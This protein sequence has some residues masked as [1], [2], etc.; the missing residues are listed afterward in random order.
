MVI[1][2]PPKSARLAASARV[3]RGFVAALL[4]AGS[5]AHAGDLSG[6]ARIIGGDTIALGE[7]RIRLQG[8]DASESDQVCLDAHGVRH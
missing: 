1:R 8:I 5:A 2:V 6:V 3:D 4:A 7:T